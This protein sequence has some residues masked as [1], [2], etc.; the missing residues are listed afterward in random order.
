MY[1]VLRRQLIYYSLMFFLFNI[2][3]SNVFESFNT[4][5]FIKASKLEVFHLNMRKKQPFLVFH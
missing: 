4:A 5:L 1:E 3:N 2:F